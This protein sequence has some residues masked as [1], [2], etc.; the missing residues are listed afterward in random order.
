[1]GAG[2]GSEARHDGKGKGKN[3]NQ[4][5]CCCLRELE[6]VVADNFNQIADLLERIFNGLDTVVTATHDH[7]QAI[8]TVIANTHG[9]Q[10]TVHGNTVATR[11][12]V[13]LLAQYLQRPPADLD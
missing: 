6:D 9:L 13:N 8:Q 10:G 12:L 5:R 3:R 1:M 4:C 2:K 7:A 11:I